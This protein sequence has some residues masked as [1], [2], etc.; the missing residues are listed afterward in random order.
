MKAVYEK[1]GSWPNDVQKVDEFIYSEYA[2]QQPPAGKMRVPNAD[3]YPS[4]EDIPPP[5]TDQL[6]ESNTRKY[7]KML[8]ACTDAAFPL[9]SAVTLGVA[10]DE[11]KAQLAELQQYAIDLINPELVDLTQLPPIFP[12]LPACIS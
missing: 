4:W 3:G 7:K 10:T 12:T 1:A 8:R 11:Q 6:I 5:T 9:Q 2:E